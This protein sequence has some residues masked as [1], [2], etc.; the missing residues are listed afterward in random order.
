MKELNMALNYFFRKPVY[1]VIC[2]LGGHVVAAKSEKSF[3]KQLGAIELEPE[4]QYDLV[5]STGEGWVFLPRKMFLSPLTFRKRWTKK[6]V[7]SLYNNRK[8]ISGTDVGYSEK[9]LS[10]KKFE[11]IFGEIVD[12]L[13][14]AATRRAIPLNR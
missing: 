11:R 7:I 8:N 3:V 14:K 1:P 5:D 12:L 2:D 9:S 6:E 13:L 4:K 10:S